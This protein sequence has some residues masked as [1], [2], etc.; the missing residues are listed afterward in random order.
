MEKRDCRKCPK[1]LN[2]KF[3]FKTGES[4]ISTI[5]SKFIPISKAIRLVQS[6]NVKDEFFELNLFRIREGASLLC[7]ALLTTIDHAVA[8]T[9]ASFYF[10]IM[11]RVLFVFFPLFTVIL[12]RG[13][14]VEPSHHK[15]DYRRLQYN[16]TSDG[17]NFKTRLFLNQ[18]NYS[19]RIDGSNEARKLE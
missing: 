3:L 16:R 12:A 1:R 2:Q 5:S 17:K 15:F 4:E 7:V 9:S 18:R 6:I 11:L 8:G 13:V 14:F 10:A 19:K